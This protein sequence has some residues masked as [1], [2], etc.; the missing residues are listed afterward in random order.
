L[1][2]KFAKASAS[3]RERQLNRLVDDMPLPWPSYREHAARAVSRIW[4]SHKPDHGHEGAMHNDTAYTLL[5]NGR[6]SV[7]KMVDGVRQREEGALTVIE[8]TAP[9]ASTRHGTLPN[10]QPRPYKGYKGDSNY[11]IEIVRN[12]KGKWE[13]EVISTFEAYQVVRQHGI[14]RL[15][16]PSRSVSGK[17]LVMRLLLDDAV[18]LIVDGN[19][20]TMRV[21][22]LSSNGQVFMSDLQ[23]ANVDARNRNKC[24]P[25]AY[26]SKYA[27]SFQKA[28]G[29]RVTVSP[30]GE[31][32]D[33]GSMG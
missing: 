12:D 7:R 23:E 8:F 11:C 32:R 30:I 26:T 29:R 5:G 24:D 19:V 10:G 15:R 4:V 20:R 2:Q 33:P 25:F 22:T 31:I 16:H 18:R 6:V 21:A 27:G 3:A 1:L 28:N 9:A 17:P 14:A 13:G